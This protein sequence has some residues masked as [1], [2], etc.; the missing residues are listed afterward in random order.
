MAEISSAV[1]WPDRGASSTPQFSLL[2]LNCSNNYRYIIKIPTNM[3][4]IHTF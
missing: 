2:G 1:S 3:Y 4:Y